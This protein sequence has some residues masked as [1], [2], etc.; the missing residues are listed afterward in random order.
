MTE[1]ISTAKDNYRSVLFLF[2]NE[3][4]LKFELKPTDCSTFYSTYSFDY[5][6]FIKT[7]VTSILSI[8]KLSK[9]IQENILDYYYAK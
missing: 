7:F 6:I 3:S 9:S 2:S 8:S 1:K 4:V 5:D